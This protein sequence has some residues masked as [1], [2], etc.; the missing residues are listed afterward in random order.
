LV[1][2]YKFQLKEHPPGPAEFGQDPHG[3]CTLG[4][5]L[6]EVPVVAKTDNSFSSSFE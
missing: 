2:E 5:I 3:L 6:L 4:A 1:L